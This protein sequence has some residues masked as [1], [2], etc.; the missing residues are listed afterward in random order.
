IVLTNR[1]Q[2]ITGSV[3]SDKGDA[4]KEYTVV[5]FPEDQQK[6]ALTGSRWRS[7]ARPDQQGQFK[8][9]DLPPGDYLAVAVEYVGQGEWNDPEWLARAAKNATKFTLSEG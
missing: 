6:W 5:V 1:T 2:T 8:I 9:V 7:S 3:T 4:L